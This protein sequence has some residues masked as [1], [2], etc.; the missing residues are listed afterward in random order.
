[1]AGLR[2]STEKGLPLRVRILL[3]PN[4]AVAAAR[5]AVPVKLELC[6]EGGKPLQPEKLHPD[7]EYKLNAAQSAAWKQ[8]EDWCGGA[9]SSFIQ[10]NRA[11]LRALTAGLVGEA[12]FFLINRPETPIPWTEAGLSGVSGHLAEPAADNSRASREPGKSPPLAA[13]RASPREP[14]RDKVAR[15]PL[16]VDGS[17]HFLCVSL[18]S[19]EDPRYR[20]ALE[21]VKS[22]DF[23][24]EPSNR[25]WWLRDRH[26]TLC[27]LS[28]HHE[29]LRGILAAEFTPN[30]QKN[31]HGLLEADV[32]AEVVSGGEGAGRLDLRLEAPGVSGGQIREA[33]QTGRPYVDLPDGKTVLVPAANIRRLEEVRRGLTGQTSAHVSPATSHELSAGET[34]AAG[35]LLENLLPGF[36]PPEEWR[37]R[38][39]ALRNLSKLTPP[40]LSDHLESV[41][42]LYQK[43]GTAWLLHLYHNNL[44]GILADEMGLGKTVQALALIAAA[45]RE[46]P[47]PEPALVVCPASLVG[48][49]RR[50]AARFTP[51]LRVFIHHREDRLTA[52]GNFGDWDVIITSYGTLLRDEELF[53]KTRFGLA[54]AD[55]AQHI[56][57]RRTRNARALRRLRARG[58]FLLTGTPVENS[59]EDLRSLFAFLMPGYL[60]AIPAGARGEDR[61]WHEDRLRRKAAPY[62]LRRTKQWVAPELPEKIEQTLFCDM[63]GQQRELYDRFLEKSRRLLAEAGAGAGEKTAPSRTALFTQLLRL[64]QI[65]CDPRLID[66][67][68]PASASAKLTAFRELLE[69]AMDGGH[70]MLVFSQFVSV[71]QLLKR[72]LEELEIPWCYLDG[73]T[74]DRLGECDRFNGDPSIPVFLISLKAGGTG[75]NL[76]GAD[77][78]VHFDPWWNP[79]A[80]AQATDRAH[81]IGQKKVVTSIK[82]IAAGTVEE[83]VLR[84]QAAK[85]SLLAD[86][87]SESE[88]SRGALSL[89][90]LGELLA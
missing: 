34:V 49:W 63:E 23:I 12:C 14:A 64:R 3:P 30:F 85:Q 31:F 33:L 29:R 35:E 17:P 71:L 53:A 61:Q 1:M 26:K 25:K 27:F 66:E 78:V 46:T 73:Q 9:A 11:Q 10:L 80:E 55:E 84:L 90:E 36:H 2:V 60:P 72:E 24:L 22:H 50:E 7:D 41:M 69:E 28:E 54:L 88:A 52:E 89:E 6:P 44:A 62:I 13:K 82:L 40:P 47:R 42:R 19:R 48:N 51:E 15:A 20:D 86:L 74:R 43:I 83:K 76:T 21:L 39:E 8:L 81:R 16:L 87:F 5:D 32:R 56:K 38:S 57:N 37:Q 79:A 59:L 67:A 68:A 77:T 58:R 65:C 70:R 45:R 4:L 18:P 75:L